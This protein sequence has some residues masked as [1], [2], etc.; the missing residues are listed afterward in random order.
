MQTGNLDHVDRLGGAAEIESTSIAAVKSL[1]TKFEQLATKTGTTTTTAVMTN[2]GVGVGGGGHASSTPQAVMVM[3][4]V[5]VNGLPPPVGPKVVFMGR[6]GVRGSG[7]GGNGNGEGN[8]NGN[9]VNGVGGAS[10]SASD[11]SRVRRP[12]TSVGVDAGGSGSGAAMF[13]HRREGA[14]SSIGSLASL[15]GIDGS[16]T[17]G[18]GGGGDFLSP[19]LH[20]ARPRASSNTEASTSANGLQVDS[21]DGGGHQTLRP[22]ASSSDLRRPPPPVPTGIKRPPPPPPPLSSSSSISMPKSAQPSQPTPIAFSPSARAGSGIGIGARSSMVELSPSR[23]PSPSVSPLLR[24]VSVPVP[25]VG[26]S[27]FSSTSSVLSSGLVAARGAGSRPPSRNGPAPGTD[28]SESEEDV[29]HSTSVASLRSKFNDAPS[30]PKVHTPRQ[31]FRNTY[32]PPSSETPSKPAIPPRPSKSHDT[33]I[34]SICLLSTSPDEYT[35]TIPTAPSPPRSMLTSSP[36][37]DDEAESESPNL[38]V[39]LVP[40]RKPPPPQPPKHINGPMRALGV[41]VGN[42]SQTSCDTASLVNPNTP[43]STPQTAS[44]RPPPPPPRTRPRVSSAMFDSPVSTPPPSTSLTTGFGTVSKTANPPPP[45]PSR[46]APAFVSS[47]PETTLSPASTLP[48]PPPRPANRSLQTSPQPSFQA[49][50]ASAKQDPPV[51]QSPGNE[52][53]LLG[54]SRLLPPPTR[55]IGLGDKLPPARRAGGGGSPPSSDEESGEEG[56]GGEDLKGT[57]V[58]DMLPD[59]SRSSRRPPFASVFRDGQLDVPKIPVHPY[60][61]HVVVAGSQLVVSH[62]H[63]IKIYDLAVADMPVITFDTKDLGLPGGAKVTCME[64]RSVGTELDGTPCLVWVGT[65]EGHVFE[66]D[67]RTGAVCAVRQV[68][69]L[70]T[71]THILRYGRNMVTLDEVGK[72]LV[73]TEGAE[74]SGP[75]GRIALTGTQPRVVRITEKQDFVRMLNGKL[76]TAARGESQ[77]SGAGGG[78]AWSRLPIIRVYDLF[79]PGSAGRSLVPSEHVGAVTSAAV[80]PSQPGKVYVGHEEGYVSIWA[81]EG[82]EDGYPR[83]VEVVKVSTSDVLCVEGVNDRLWVGS[84]NGMISAYEVMARPWIVTNSWSAHPGLPV[85]KMGV[86][87]VGMVEG[88]LNV[89]SIGRDETIRFWDGLLGLDWIENEMQKRENSFSSFRDVTTLIVSWNCDAAR[90]DSLTGEAA[91]VNLFNDILTTVDSPPD[92]IAFGFQEVIDLESRKMAAKNVLL[93]GAAKKKHN[94]EGS[95][96]GHACSGNG[97]SDKVT[98][99]YRRWYDRLVKEVRLAMP[100]VPYTVV[101][102]ESL[103]GLFSCIFVKASERVALRDVAVTTV[104]R[105]MGGRYGNKGGIVARFVMGDSS[106]CMINCHL[107]AGQN[108]VRRR[109]ADIA[110]ILEEKAVFPPTDYPLSYVGGGDGS[111]VLDHEIVIVNGDMNYRIEARREAIVSSIRTKEYANLLAYDQLLR[112]IKNNRACRFRGF[113]EGSIMFAPTYKYDPRSN[114]YD[115]SEKRR[116]P[117]WCDRVLWRVRD[118]S[119]VHQLHYRRYE[120]NVSDHRPVSAAFRMTIKIIGH[121]LRAQIHRQVEMLWAEQQARL[122]AEAREFYRKYVYL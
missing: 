98:G 65:K 63:H 87:V 7:G 19:G 37:S 39:P 97:L 55:T 72:A 76:W 33:P 82:T 60:S 27:S 31:G 92:V 11:K 18:G 62:N 57:G 115:T 101:Y 108:A 100:D 90:P 10:A 84:R 113:S 20:N 122:L 23:A 80:L 96:T 59:S 109:N 69:H 12:N 54:S 81:V 28:V 4:S 83:C 50:G 114:E 71:V 6:V 24:P 42:S 34:S 8:G 13:G 47:D 116:S 121:D 99:A 22:S 104:K 85:L 103:V 56:G 105:G 74:G 2:S 32:P 94:D 3:P 41:R 86:D 91:N 43:T 26:P 53:K 66:M 73:F 45:L 17:L 75:D 70:H 29:Q 46:R 30:P 36:F 40:T 120:A 77:S 35:L 1:R 67:V 16:S 14:G 79:A 95:I 61:G 102:T 119:R 112:E 25:S 15:S 93:G 58:V 88:R 107:A 38:A 9:V 106:V 89:V 68:A 49:S 118:A 64:L 52:R 111:M 21:V 117:A 78:V 5:I 44:P 48:P 51:T 110:A